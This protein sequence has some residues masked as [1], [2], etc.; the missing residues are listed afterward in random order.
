MEIDK[1]TYNNKT[2]Y[3]IGNYWWDFNPR[4]MML[5][6]GFLIFLAGWFYIDNIF[7]LIL[8]SISAYFVSVVIIGTIF[9][10][11]VTKSTEIVL[12]VLQEILAKP[13]DDDLDATF[14]DKEK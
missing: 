6:L 11:D 3:K 1:L 5:L 10:S 8:N 4:L 14:T 2:Y 13:D 9:Y 12:Y 7:L